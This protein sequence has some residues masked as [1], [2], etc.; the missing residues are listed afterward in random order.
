MKLRAAICL[1]VFALPFTA[2]GAT[3][4]DKTVRLKGVCEPQANNRAA[5]CNSIALI[6]PS[7]YPGYVMVMFLQGNHAVAGFSGRS[8]TDPADHAERLRVDN[9]YYPDRT[10]HIYKPNGEEKTEQKPG[11]WEAHPGVCEFHHNGGPLSAVECGQPLWSFTVSAS[12]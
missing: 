2:T 8:Y 12:Q 4:A 11:A 1:A 9:I 5:P 6:Y 3:V 7:A 10:T